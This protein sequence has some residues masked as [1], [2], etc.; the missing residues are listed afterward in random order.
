MFHGRKR[1]EKKELSAEEIAEIEAKLA[2]IGQNNKILLSKR[3]N[4][5][6]T[7]ETLKQTEKFSF[8]SPDF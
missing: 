4:K 2:K 3:A 5:E 8:L 6:Y 7:Q 1:T